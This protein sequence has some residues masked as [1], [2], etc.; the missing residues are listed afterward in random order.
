[1]QIQVTYG[2]LRLSDYYFFLDIVKEIPDLDMELSISFIEMKAL[3]EQNIKSCWGDL[4]VICN[5]LDDYASQIDKY[6][7]DNE[8]V[9]MTEFNYTY[10]ADRCRKISDKIADQIGYDKV[11][12]LE[13]CKK[14]QVSD[15]DIGEEAL[16]LSVKRKKGS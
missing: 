13:K 12:T 5:A 3:S 11:K 14:K 16:V 15:S 9:G 2:R 8:L 10:H 1:M 4:F 7:K 6:V